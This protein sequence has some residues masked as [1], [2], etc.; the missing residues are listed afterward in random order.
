MRK[1]KILITT[2]FFSPTNSPRAFRI[3]ALAK[4]L[5]ENGHEVTVV[6]SDIGYDYTQIEKSANLKIIAIKSGYLLNK[7]SLVKPGETASTSHLSAPSVFSIIK[8]RIRKTMLY[9][10]PDAHLFEY[11]ISLKNSL[12][13]LDL[14]S[15]DVIISNSHPFA[16][17]L[18]TALAMKNYNNISI[19]E[20]GDPHYYN[21]IKLAFYQKN[22][23]KW[24]LS[25]FS[26]ITIPLTKA[27]ED[28]ARL[29]VKSKVT[30][31][32][33]GFDFERVKLFEPKNITTDVVRFAFAGRLYKNLRDPSEFLDF[34]VKKNIPFTFTIYTDFNNRETMELLAPYEKRLDG[35]LIIHPL[36]PRDE[37]IYLL[38][39]NDFLINI[40][41]TSE[42]QSPSKLIDYSLTKRPIL[43]ISSQFTEQSKFDA[44]FDKDYSQ[45]VPLDISQFNINTVCEKFEALFD[46]K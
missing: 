41:N 31:I 15:F 34:L 13:K 46:Q 27:I 22:I 2:Y 7:P 4:K 32:P 44:F 12:K 30:V 35:K 23:E 37:C 26:H 20:S 28:Y 6:T 3:T 39:N 33:H 24:V 1:K 10:I 19:A 38:S 25:K 16:V 29:D 9:L 40:A 14:N 45:H 17:H 42:N 21:F 8:T 18:G 11:A 5:A 43:T 36:V